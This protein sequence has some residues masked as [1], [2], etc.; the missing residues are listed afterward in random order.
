MVILGLLTF[1][2]PESFAK[3]TGKAKVEPT[4]NTIQVT[5]TKAG[6]LSEKFEEADKKGEMESSAPFVSPADKSPKDDQSATETNPLKPQ[7]TQGPS[8]SAA[9]GKGKQIKWQVVSSGANIGGTPVIY[10][11][12]RTDG[13]EL[14]GTIGQVGVGSGSSPSYSMNS[15]FW[16]EFLQGYIRGDVNGDGVIDI[17]DVVYLLNWV[18]FGGPE[19]APLWVGDVNCDGVV[20]IED[21]IYLVNYIFIS[22]PLPSC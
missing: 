20:D 15:G 5:S 8:A 10:Q 14:S 11:L 2:V 17:A 16:Q 7:Q 18:F 12:G 6:L 13:N 9:D 21:V 1:S 22:G 3:E 4:K 19:P